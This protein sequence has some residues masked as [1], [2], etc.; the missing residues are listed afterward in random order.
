MPSHACKRKARLLARLQRRIPVWSIWYKDSDGHESPDAA[1]LFTAHIYD[2]AVKQYIEETMTCMEAEQHQVFV[3]KLHK[4]HSRDKDKKFDSCFDEFVL[5]AARAVQLDWETACNAFSDW[6]RHSRKSQ[7][8]C[9][10]A[11]GSHSK[12]SEQ[13]CHT[14]L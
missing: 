14:E 11:R 9:V 8:Y 7:L 5:G 4:L 10:H 6:S 12:K 1:Q 3:C 13:T 2:P